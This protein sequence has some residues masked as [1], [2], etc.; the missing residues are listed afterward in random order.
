VD[1]T[2]LTDP[3]PGSPRGNRRPPHHRA[4]RPALHRPT[5]SV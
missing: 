3:S 5:R 4:G 1:G 2:T